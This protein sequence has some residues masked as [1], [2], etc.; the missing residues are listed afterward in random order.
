MDIDLVAEDR[1]G[2]PVLIL[3]SWGRVIASGSIALG[4]FIDDLASAPKSG[5]FGM[6]VDPKTI[7]VLRRDGDCVASFST[8]DVF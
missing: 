2:R 1:D 8:I 3:K 7:Y 6:F 4:R 5:E